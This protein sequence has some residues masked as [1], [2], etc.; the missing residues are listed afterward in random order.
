MSRSKVPPFLP[1]PGL[2]LAVP[3]RCNRAERRRWARRGPRTHRQPT[4]GVSDRP[5]SFPASRRYRCVLRAHRTDTAAGVPLVFRARA[6]APYQCVRVTPLCA[7][8]PGETAYVG[9]GVLWATGGRMVRCAELG[10]TPGESPA[11]ITCVSAR[12]LPLTAAACGSRSVSRRE[13]EVGEGGAPRPARSR[14]STRETL[15]AL[16]P[17]A[18]QVS[19]GLHRDVPGLRWHQP[20]LYRGQ[21]TREPLALGIPLVKTP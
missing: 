12:L 7:A 17:E 4:H 19:P 2:L 21:T 10:R 15:V 18:R 8:E 6:S 11:R 14:D 20:C 1:D 5:T 9:A 16:Y 13:A 3:L